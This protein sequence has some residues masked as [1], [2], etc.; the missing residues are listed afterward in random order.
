MLDSKRSESSQVYSLSIQQRFFYD[1][2]ES[3]DDRLS[4]Q[5]RQSRPAGDALYDIC[6]RHEN[7]RYVDILC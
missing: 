5:F 1:T 3:V 4:F 2:Y 7:I 6:L